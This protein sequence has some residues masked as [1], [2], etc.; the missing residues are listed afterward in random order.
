VKEIST[1]IV[2]KKALARRTFLRGA[3]AVLSLPLLEAMVPALTAE[4]RTA[5]APVPRIGFIYTPNGFMKDY[6]VPKTAGREFQF[7][8]SLEALEAFRTKVTLITGLAHRQADPMGDPPGPHSRACGA[9]LTGVH[10]KQTEGADVRAAQSV[11]QIA[12]AMIGQ[13]SPLPSLELATEQNEMLVGNCE[14][15][16][17]CVYQNTISW[18]NATTP[19]PMEVHPRVVFERLFGDGGTPAEQRTQLKTER[20]ILDSVNAQIADLQRTLGPSDRYR[21]SQ[22]LDSVRE[23]EAR[24]QR[25]EART[26]EPDFALPERPVDIPASFDEHVK[27]MFDL[28]TLA[29]QADITRVITFQLGR[30]LSP[31]A[32]PHI[33]V[34]AAHHAVSHH[35]G[36]PTKIA[37]KAKIDAYHIQ[38]VAYYAERLQ[39][40]PDGDGTLLD[41]VAV[42]YGS[43]LGEPN[44]HDPFNLPSVIVGTAYGR[45]NAGRH[46]AFNMRE[47]TPQA[48]LLMSL[49]DKVGAPIEKLGDSTGTLRELSDI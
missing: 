33:G 38:L 10:V 31:R 16:Y 11:D 41:H 30:E 44:G 15:G 9:W 37:M 32:Y 25:S 43:G 24:I 12:A 2:T 13:E 40:T 39:A 26:S 1:M 34:P 46:L 17:S 6:W 5:A 18:R 8:P 4:S 20:S 47:Y 29:Y 48:N 35:G 21:V 36:D 45:I 19:M 42:L 22:Y 7:T 23:I 27:L 3:G 14:A 49:M 28:Q